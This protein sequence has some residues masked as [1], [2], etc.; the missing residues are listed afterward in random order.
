MREDVDAAVNPCRKFFEL[1]VKARIMAAAMQVVGMENVNDKPTGE[2]LQPDLPNA[3]NKEKKEYLRK[4]ASQVIDNF[5]IRR[6]KVEAILN[7]LLTAEEEEASNTREQ[8]DSGRFI[9]QFPGCGKTFAHNGK[10]MR[11]HEATHSAHVSVGD[12]ERQEV[13]ETSPIKPP[14]KDDMFSYQCSFLEFGMIILNF[15]DAIKEGDGKR[16]LRSW[17][18]QLPYLRK[19]PGSTKYALE[20]LGLLFQVYGL[21]SPKDSHEL[22]WN[23]SALLSGHNIPLDLLLEFFNRLLKEVERNLGPNATNHKAI[24]R[25]CHAIDITKPA[26]DNFDRECGV[27]RRSGHHYEISVTSDIHKV[28]TELNTQKAFCWT[29][30]RTYGHYK[31]I[32]SSLLDG[33]DLKDMFRWI[34]NHKKYIVKS[35]RA[36]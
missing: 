24:D 18:F 12:S 19:D 33:F 8:T 11:D 34:N 30:G 1:E 21:L 13:P 25:Y 10:R 20:A 7:S 31:D 2:F 15:F 5:V 26:L 17:K 23:R 3:V 9:C 32:D 27:I 22:I 4:I 14:E 29:P 35:R 36:R 28:I 6:E 16:I